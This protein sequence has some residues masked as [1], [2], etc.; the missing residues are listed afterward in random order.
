MVKARASGELRI[1]KI[2]IEA[3]LIAGDD[4]E[5]LQD[6][7]A[8][9]CNAALGNAQRGVQQEFQ[10]LSG[11]MPGFPGFPGGGGQG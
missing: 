4:P 8:A 9:A 5:M 1:M 6:L 10:R 3:V 2:E 7:V 11:G